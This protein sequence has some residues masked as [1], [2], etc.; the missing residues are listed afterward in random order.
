MPQLDITAYSTQLFW[1]FIMLSLIYLVI[2][3]YVLPHILRSLRLRT[4]VL[5][6]INVSAKTDN[7]SLEKQLHSNLSLF[8][9]TLQR[10]ADYKVS[11]TT[12]YDDK[13]GLLLDKLN[14]LFFKRQLTAFISATSYFPQHKEKNIP[15][16][17]TIGIFAALFSLSDEFI[18]MFCFSLFALIFVFAAKTY[19]KETI[20]GKISEIRSRFSGPL[21]LKLAN[22]NAKNELLKK[23]SLLT[24]D[25]RK[26]ST[27]LISDLDRYTRISDQKFF[28]I[29]V[30]SY[31]ANVQTNANASEITSI[32][33]ILNSYFKQQNT[34]P[35]VSS[36]YI[37]R[38]LT[39]INM[40]NHNK[41]LDHLLTEMLKDAN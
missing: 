32:Q 8:V 14:S 33:R 2:D 9:E 6:S 41:M 35:K 18:L 11:I 17:R 21:E 34:T 37:D 27:R 23:I 25:K 5:D 1:V 24:K 3:L 7:S 13:K 36:N 15:H 29:K 19:I 40:S 12:L 20:D 16:T 10:I 31:F 30:R 28:E 22:L 39:S 26:F 4:R 38:A